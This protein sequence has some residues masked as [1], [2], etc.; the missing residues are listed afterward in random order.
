MHSIATIIAQTPR[1]HLV[2]CISPLPLIAMAPKQ[3]RRRAIPKAKRSFTGDTRRLRD[4][5]ADAIPEES[6]STGMIVCSPLG[7][8]MVGVPASVADL[9]KFAEYLDIGELG[10]VIV[11]SVHCVTMLPCEISLAHFMHHCLTQMLFA[12]AA[13]M[14]AAQK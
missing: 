8:G 13:D 2:T 10:F 12:S 11:A 5:D 7:F 4:Y 1:L 9:A 3:H 14:G 6:E